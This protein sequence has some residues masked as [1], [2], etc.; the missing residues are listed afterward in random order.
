[1]LYETPLKNLFLIGPEAGA[2]TLVWLAT[3][4]P[5]V[6]WQPGEYYY[7]R[8]PGRKHKQASDPELAK[9]FFDASARLV[10]LA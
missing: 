10:G 5:G 1:M 2:D 9:R 6:D 4:R 7:K 8:K 3:S